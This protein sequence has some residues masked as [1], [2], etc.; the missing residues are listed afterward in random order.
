[1]R[2]SLPSIPHNL[3]EGLRRIGNDR[4]HLLT[5]ALGSAEELARLAP[6]TDE[7][8]AAVCAS[9]ARRWHRHRCLPRHSHPRGG[10]GRRRARGPDLRD[11]LLLAP[12]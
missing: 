1:M 7:T 4:S 3:C 6:Q 5:V 12:T 9:L 10:P 8:W 11:A 2:R